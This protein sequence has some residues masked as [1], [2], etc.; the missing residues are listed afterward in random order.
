MNRESSDC[1]IQTTRDSLNYMLGN[2][3]L[4]YC[5]RRSTFRNSP[6]IQWVC[7]SENRAAFPLPERDHRHK[8]ENTLTLTDER[9]L[10]RK[11]FHLLNT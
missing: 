8:F 6:L 7:C 1:N 2:D 10:K 5:I 9:I 3:F 11:S 4:I